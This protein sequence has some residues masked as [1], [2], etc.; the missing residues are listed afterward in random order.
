MRGVFHASTFSMLRCSSLILC[1]LLLL[2]KNHAFNINKLATTR[3]ADNNFQVAFGTMKKKNSLTFLQGKNRPTTTTTTAG[4]TFAC[5]TRLRQRASDIMDTRDN[6]EQQDQAP[7]NATNFNDR[8]ERKE[9]KTRF[10]R[11]KQRARLRFFKYLDQGGRSLLHWRRRARNTQTQSSSSKL[12]S[13]VVDDDETRTDDKENDSSRT[14]T[15]SLPTGP[16]WAVAHPEIDLSGTWKPVVTNEFK[17]EYDTYLQNCGTNFAFRQVC[18][19]FCSMV[20][21]TI[22]QEDHG[23]VL[24]LMDTSPGGSWK[25]S[26]ISSGANYTC[27]ASLSQKSRV[28]EE[29]YQPIYTS[30]VDPDNEIVQ[31]E[32]WWENQGRVHT[33]FLRNKPKVRGGEFESKRYLTTDEATGEIQLVCESSFHPPTAL[34]NQTSSASSKSSTSPFKPAFVRWTYQRV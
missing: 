34:M 29:D 27:S 14:T 25:R 16:R 4:G 9:G 11:W 8:Q 7:R 22:Q 6:L 5:T 21:E 15:L 17:K 24:H 18:L 13:N 28:V 19:N 31:V 2:P 10:Q 33:S 12:D 20:R 30:F 32:A 1:S 26:L 3:H 23:R